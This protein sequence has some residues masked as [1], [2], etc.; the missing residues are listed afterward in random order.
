MKELIFVKEGEEY[1]AVRFEEFKELV[2]RLN[3]QPAWVSSMKWLSEQ[4][5]GRS[6]EWLRMN[7]LYPYRK[8]LE[9]FVAYPESSGQPWRFNIKPMKE[10]LEQDKNFRRVHQ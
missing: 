9:G 4:T 2:D 7:L 1:I 3:E 6:P 5:G 10:W 8:E